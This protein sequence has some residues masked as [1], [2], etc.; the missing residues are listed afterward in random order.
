MEVAPLQE[1]EALVGK[2]GHQEN[3]G[4]Q[5]EEVREETQ[6]MEG[7]K[8]GLE[9]L[10]EDLQRN[11][12]EAFAVERAWEE[13]RTFEQV[14]RRQHSGSRFLSSCLRVQRY[15]PSGPCVPLT[16]P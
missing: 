7:E 1:Q 12:V 15:S 16:A 2:A 14:H 8:A 11:W 3:R 10:V 5:V 6:Q 13:Q 4:S 9:N